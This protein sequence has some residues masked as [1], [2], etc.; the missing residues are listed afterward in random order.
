MMSIEHEGAGNIF[1]KIAELSNNFTS[2]QDA[3]KTFQALNNSLKEFEQDLHPHIH[4]EN[5]ILLCPK[6]SVLEKQLTDK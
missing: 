4:L 2:R 6:T 5:N 3:F 1:N